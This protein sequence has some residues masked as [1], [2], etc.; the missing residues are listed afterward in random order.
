MHL[1]NVNLCI[2]C[3]VEALCVIKIKIATFEARKLVEVFVYLLSTAKISR[4]AE[5]L[6]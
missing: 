3:L 2:D 1:L 5:N 6:D 4:K